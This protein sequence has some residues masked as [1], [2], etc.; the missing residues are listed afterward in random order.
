MSKWVRI[1][2]SN[3]VQEVIYYNPFEIVNEE[4]HPFFREVSGEETYGWIYDPDTGTFSAPPPPPEEP[5][6]VATT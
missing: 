1:D 2:S 4:F 5:V 6:G 3:T